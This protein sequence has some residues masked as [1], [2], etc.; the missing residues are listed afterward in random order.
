MKSNLSLGK[1]NCASALTRVELLTLLMVLA[2]LACVTLPALGSAWGRSEQG[3]CL[4]NLRQIGRAFAEWGIGHDDQHPWWVPAEQG[5]TYP[6]AG[7]SGPQVVASYAGNPWFQFAWISNE[8]R[9]PRILACPADPKRRPANDFSTSAEGGL[10]NPSQRNNAISYALATDTHEAGATFLVA[11]DRDLRIDGTGRC[12]AGFY[13]TVNLIWN[14]VR[15]GGWNNEL[16]Q[17]SG[18]MLFLDGH[19][20][21]VP[22]L[23]FTN[24]LMWADA[25]GSVHLLIP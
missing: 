11:A 14:P 3:V 25:N 1:Q 8:L 7:L 6:N 15:N 13:N 5:G 4:N 21:E 2:L 20:E 19:V 16:H 22:L 24:R 18:N 9:T 17:G 10:L 23:S 12:S